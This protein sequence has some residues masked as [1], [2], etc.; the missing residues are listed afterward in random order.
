[1]PFSVPSLVQAM[2]VGATPGMVNALSPALTKG[3]K[4]LALLKSGVEGA[5]AGYAADEQMI[6][7]S[8]GGR[9]GGAAHLVDYS[10]QLWDNQDEFLKQR[11]PLVRRSA[12]PWYGKAAAKSLPF[13]RAQ[14]RSGL[15]TRLHV[16]RTNLP[17]W[18]KAR[19][20]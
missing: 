9:A 18:S 20:H 2:Q 19:R 5:L 4:I 14:T 8:E 11:P 10:R 3:G 1:M 16:F 7:A 13:H 6:A 15:F 17:S 12:F